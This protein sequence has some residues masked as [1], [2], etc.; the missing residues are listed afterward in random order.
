MGKKSKYYPVIKRGVDCALST[1]AVI[2]LSPV[3]AAIAICIK[4]EDPKGPVLFKQK[5]VGEKKKLFDIYKFRSM[6]QDA[7]HDVATEDLDDP[8]KYVTKTGRILRK[9]SL[10]E[11]PQFFNVIKGDMSIVAPR[12]ALWNQYNLIK[13]RDKYT[14]LDGLTPNDIRPGITGWAQVNGRDDNDDAEKA[15]LDGEYVQKLSFWMDCKCFLQTI[16]KV[17]RHE[18]VKG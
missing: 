17:F 6:Y 18:G 16:G 15:R 4:A 7:P 13:E 8:L 12:P 5:R 2:G 10:D 3:M 1:A 14:G 11:L 9:Y